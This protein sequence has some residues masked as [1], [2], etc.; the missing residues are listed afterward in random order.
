MLGPMSLSAATDPGM[1]W[2]AR[3]ELQV[4]RQGNAAI[5]GRRSH[6]GPLRIQRPFYPEGPSPL[7]LYLLHPPGGLVGGDRLDVSVIVERD[8]AALIT[9][10]A[11]QK[12]Y[13][14]AGA[15][16]VQRT[17]LTVKA[18]A[19]LEWFPSETLAFDGALAR[20]STRVQLDSGATYIGWELGCWGRPASGQT[21]THG[22]VQ[23]QLEIYRDQCPL[24]VE[25]VRV[26]GGSSALRAPWGYAGHPAFGA[27][28]CVPAVAGA[29]LALVDKVRERVGTPELSAFGVS[30]MD[31]LLVARASADN[32]EQIRRVL[33]QVWQTLR[34]EISGRPAEL[35]RIWAT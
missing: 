21:F 26:R 1:G 12:L 28:Y 6:R 19:T 15:E 4:L 35:P 24:I 31:D 9:T 27:L 2:A 30:A 32:V 14:S 5:L 16:S 7:H 20:S 3:L 13:R 18:G 23:Q 25:R 34:P 11:A 10:P 8:A 33:V 17:E 22:A 29:S